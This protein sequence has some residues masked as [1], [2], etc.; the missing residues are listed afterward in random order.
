MSVL[1]LPKPSRGGRW[2]MVIDS[3][4][5]KAPFLT[6]PLLC[7]QGKITIKP[8]AIQVFV[9]KKVPTEGKTIKRGRSKANG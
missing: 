2:Y 5:D 3:S 4:D 7:E 9:G 1:A 8:Q 6:E